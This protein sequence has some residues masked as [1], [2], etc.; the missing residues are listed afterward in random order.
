MQ[1][2]GCFAC[3]SEK[4]EIEWKMSI[5]RRW[6]EKWRGKTQG[7]SSSIQSKWMENRYELLSLSLCWLPMKEDIH[8]N[9]WKLDEEHI[10][11]GLSKRKCQ[12]H[13][14]VVNR[15]SESQLYFHG[16]WRSGI[17]KSYPW[18]SLN[19][20][21]YPTIVWDDDMACVCMCVLFWGVG[22]AWEQKQ[23]SVGEQI[24]QH[25]ISPYSRRRVLCAIL[26]MNGSLI[27]FV[28]LLNSLVSRSLSSS[29]S[30]WEHEKWN[31]HIKIAVVIPPEWSFSR[32]WW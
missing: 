30:A 16:K 4:R 19:I 15:A 22:R 11:K 12:C 8:G 6:R 14:S 1:K 23:A 2:S 25:N 10:K 26:S 9:G 3:E 5:W 7:W 31:V 24:R 18:H 32:Q 21:L 28:I 13:H 20:N 17:Q 29:F 27:L